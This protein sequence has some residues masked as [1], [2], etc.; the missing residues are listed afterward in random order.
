M[1]VSGGQSSI[2]GY[3]GKAVNRGSSTLSAEAMVGWQAVIVK[4]QPLIPVTADIAD[5]CSSRRELTGYG[6]AVRPTVR[7]T[8][9]PAVRACMMHQK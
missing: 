9:D 4:T 5:C 1:G 7:S 6:S 2:V 8:Q 3:G